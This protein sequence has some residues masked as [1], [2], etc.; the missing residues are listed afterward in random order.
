MAKKLISLNLFTFA[1]PITAK[2]SILHRIS[3]VVLLFNIPWFLR[4]LED[5]LY[6]PDMLEGYSVFYMWF[7][8]SV[9]GYHLLA[10][11]R[12]LQMDD[13]HWEDVAKARLSAYLVLIV[14]VLVSMFIGWSL[15]YR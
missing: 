5:V 13:G 6:Y 14:S 4:L 9:L 1:F 7:V 8:F 2:V 11:V 15:C 12:H 10:G 3:G